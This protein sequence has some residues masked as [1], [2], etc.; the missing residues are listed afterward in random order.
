[1]AYLCSQKWEQQFDDQEYRMNLFNIYLFVSVA[2]T[3]DGSFRFMYGRF[4]EESAAI[5]GN[6]E[7][8]KAAVLIKECGD[9]WVSMAAPFKEALTKDKPASLIDKAVDQLNDIAE[10]EKAAFQMLHDL[11]A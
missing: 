2:G 4:L 10:K 1:M 8:V 3:G 6:Q 11:S 5:T 9:A 7:L